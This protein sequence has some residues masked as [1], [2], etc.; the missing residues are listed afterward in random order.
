MCEFLYM[1]NLYT[2][3]LSQM[4]TLIHAHKHTSAPICTHVIYKRLV[5]SSVHSLD[6]FI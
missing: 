5:R 2:N 3:A 6:F 1:I 4:Y